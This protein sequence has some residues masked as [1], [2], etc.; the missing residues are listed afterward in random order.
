MKQEIW[1][2]DEEFRIA[3]KEL[4]K[5]KKLTNKELGNIASVSDR[6]IQMIIAGE[7]GAGK[8]TSEKIAAHFGLSYND[9]L[10]IGRHKIEGKD[11]QSVAIQSRYSKDIRLVSIPLLNSTVSAGHHI[12]TVEGAREMIQMPESIVGRKT[13]EALAMIIV[14]GDSMEPALED[15]D[16]VIFDG[17]QS[18]IDGGGI[19]VIV[20]GERLAV[21][22]LQLMHDGKIMIKSDNP[23]YNTEIV[24]AD[25]VH[26]KGRVIWYGRKMG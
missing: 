25:Q 19:F 14:R 18:G 20:V 9:M 6:F 5:E 26:I 12:A 17:N 10:K 4:K 2:I 3:L 13:S 7:R 23:A 11:Q 21:K 15:G 24:P 22:R 1:P 8:E 16:T